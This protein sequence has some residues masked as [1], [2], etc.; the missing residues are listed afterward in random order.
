MGEGKP[1]SA[2]TKYLYVERRINANS[3]A[4]GELVPFNA[5][6][7][8]KGNDLVPASMR[9]APFEVSYHWSVKTRE[10]AIDEEAAPNLCE[11]PEWTL[12]TG[13]DSTDEQREEA[14]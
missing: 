13:R 8:P 9:P 11:N 3:I 2:K 4:F 5:S 1:S 10:I 7:L 14:D 6:S 12:G